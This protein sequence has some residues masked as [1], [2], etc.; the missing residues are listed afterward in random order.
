MNNEQWLFV[1]NNSRGCKSGREEN[2]KYGF[3][4]IRHVSYNLPT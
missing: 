3:A 4:G 1:L 2:K